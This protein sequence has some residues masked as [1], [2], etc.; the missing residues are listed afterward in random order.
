MTELR[1]HECGAP[2]AEG[3]EIWLE[4]GTGRPDEA[5]GEPFCPGCA[6]PIGIAA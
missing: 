6:H 4:P 1:C 3:D 5:S 2:L